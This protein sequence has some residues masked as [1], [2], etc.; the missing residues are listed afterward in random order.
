MDNSEYIEQLQL[1]HDTEVQKPATM[2]A[3]D[4]D[5]DEI[6]AKIEELN[7]TTD[8]VPKTDVTQINSKNYYIK[9]L[10]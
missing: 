7:E 4:I 8:Q 1:P 10:F 2:A 9:H 5:F 3:I 6:K